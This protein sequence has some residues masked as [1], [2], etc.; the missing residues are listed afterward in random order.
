MTGVRELEHRMVLAR[1]WERRPKPTTD[2]PEPKDPGDSAAYMERTR[3]MY[4]MARLAFETD[5][6]RL[7]TVY[8]DSAAS[9]AISIEGVDITDG[10]HNLSHHGERTRAS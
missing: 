1:E 3:L 5:S 9:P 4:D 6:T 8:L 2:E 7:V 10:Y